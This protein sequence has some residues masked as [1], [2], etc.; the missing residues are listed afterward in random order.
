M[1]AEETATANVNNKK[2]YNYIYGQ[3]TTIH[4]R[5]KKRIRTQK[6]S[7]LIG[8]PLTVTIQA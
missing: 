3:K 1:S 4:T 6:S 5:K 7:K 2:Q 8:Y